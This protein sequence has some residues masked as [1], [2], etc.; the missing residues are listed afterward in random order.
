[1]PFTKSDVDHLRG[2]LDDLDTLLS[3]LATLTEKRIVEPGES[4]IATEEVYRNLLDLEEYAE[5]MADE[6]RQ[7]RRAFEE[8]APR[9][10]RTWPRRTKG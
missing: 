8:P 2:L 4:D 9:P 1:M 3:V 5:L 6:A 7:Y 10:Q